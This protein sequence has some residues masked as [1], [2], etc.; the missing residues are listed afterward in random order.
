[1]LVFGLCANHHRFDFSSFLVCNTNYI[2]KELLIEFF[3]GG[4]VFDTFDNCNFTDKFWQR[5]LKQNSSEA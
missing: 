5:G 4:D 2:I 1:M 3:W